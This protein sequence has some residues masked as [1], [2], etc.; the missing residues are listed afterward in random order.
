MLLTGQLHLLCGVSLLQYDERRAKM[1]LVAE[2]LLAREPIPDPNPCVYA[3]ASPQRLKAFFQQYQ[4]AVRWRS[5]RF[6]A[7]HLVFFYST[8]CTL[9][10]CV[11][12]SM[13]LRQHDACNSIQNKST[14][15]S[16]R[17]DFMVLWDK[18]STCSFVR[19]TCRRTRY[20]RSAW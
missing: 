10:F 2:L 16:S 17:L 20:W 4:E 7:S 5:A 8:D 9:G 18:R 3:S 6:S 14:I 13:H 11:P 19:C 12:A 1:R 15:V